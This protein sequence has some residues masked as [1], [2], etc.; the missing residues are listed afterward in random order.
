VGDV[1][2]AAY[3]GFQVVGIVSS[4]DV[5]ASPE[6]RPPSVVLRGKRTVEFSEGEIFGWV[7]DLCEWE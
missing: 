6:G 7:H 3:N 4:P 2:K 1:G 5:L